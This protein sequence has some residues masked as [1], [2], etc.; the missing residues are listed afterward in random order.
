[1]AS[2]FSSSTTGAGDA[3]IVAGSG[4]VASGFFSSWGASTFSSSETG[5][6][7]A[8]TTVGSGDVTSGFVSA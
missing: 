5:A 3:F 4:D 8:Y 7:D 2:T 6:G 1:M